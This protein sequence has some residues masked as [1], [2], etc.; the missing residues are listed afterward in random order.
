[1]DTNPAT[2]VT[3]MDGL[4]AALEQPSD[5]TPDEP[6]DVVEPEVAEDET[7]EA[8]ATDSEDEQPPADD[9]EVEIDGE[10]L[11]VPKKVAEAV[12]RH[13]DYTKK[14]QEVAD[15]RRAIEDKEHFLE[16]QQQ[17]MSVAAGAMA[18]L[19]AKQER[20]AQFEAIDWNTLVQQDSQ[21]A[22]ELHIARNALQS[23]VQQELHQLQNA[24]TAVAEAKKKHDENQ[25]ALNR[26]ELE[27]RVGK[28]T[29]KDR[30][31]LM[32]TAQELGWSEQLMWRPEAL[33][34]L[35]LASKYLALQK[36]KPTAMKKVAE[37]PR[38]IK[39]QAAP[40]RKENQS[41]AERL[42]K[43]GRAENLI[44]FL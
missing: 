17:F 43:T 29:D 38:A 42:K 1:M 36:A 2:E 4:L 40:P 24:R 12:M 35:D 14:T 10:K 23:E 8:E 16:A 13:Q 18:K 5:D 20:L 19:Q 11:K 37:A 39:P 21:R 9:E 26:P 30:Q 44:N 6:S 32:A 15:R 34:A 3:E 28:I 33:H 31:R 41:A 7:D 22:L 27:R 25:I